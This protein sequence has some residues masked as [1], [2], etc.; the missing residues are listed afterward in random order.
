VTGPLPDCGKIVVNYQS[1]FDSQR[2]VLTI[3]QP[4]GTTISAM[5]NNHGPSGRLSGENHKYSRE[6]AWEMYC[7]SLYE[8]ATVP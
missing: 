5:S 8:K 1:N 7:R 6:R 3:S 4:G 2:K